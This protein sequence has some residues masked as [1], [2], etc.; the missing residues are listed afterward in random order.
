[1]ELA[2]NKNY[3]QLD[4]STTTKIKNYSRKYSRKYSISK[5]IIKSH[6]IKRQ[7]FFSFRC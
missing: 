1:M 4:L 3:W 7:N 5:I 2:K 6:Q